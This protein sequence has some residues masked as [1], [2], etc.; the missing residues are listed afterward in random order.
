MTVIKKQQETAFTAHSL[1]FSFKKK[2][3]KA[4][5]QLLYSFRGC[6]FFKH[7]PEIQCAEDHLK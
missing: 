4:K 6:G 7:F 1:T 5:N 3:K 2:S